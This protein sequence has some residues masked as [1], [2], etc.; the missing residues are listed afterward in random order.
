MTMAFLFWFLM[1]LALL[2]GWWREYIPGQPY[3]YHRGL[4]PVL[5]FVLLGILGWSQFGAPIH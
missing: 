5:L 4:Y 2:F 3:P 1:L